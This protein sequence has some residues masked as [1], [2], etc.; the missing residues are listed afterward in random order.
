MAN[1]GPF[2]APLLALTLLSLPGMVLPV[3]AR[4]RG[5]RLSGCP[6][7]TTISRR[8]AEEGTG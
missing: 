4:S 3:Q 1:P 2:C 6:A 7:A 5:D 8:L